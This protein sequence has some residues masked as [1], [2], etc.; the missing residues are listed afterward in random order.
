MNLKES[1]GIKYRYFY[2]TQRKVV[3]TFEI[4][5]TEEQYDFKANSEIHPAL[6]LDESRKYEGFTEDTMMAIEEEES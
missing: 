5:N 6:G 3:R 2:E 4:L 1:N